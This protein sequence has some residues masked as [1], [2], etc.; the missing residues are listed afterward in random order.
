MHAYLVRIATKA[1][2]YARDLMAR[3]SWLLMFI[4]GRFTVF[5]SFYVRRWQRRTRKPPAH[6]A[7]GEALSTRRPSDIADILR[8]D[9]L[10]SGLILPRRVSRDIAEFAERAQCY[11]YMDRAMPFLA[12]HHAEA[13]QRYGQSI[14]VGHFLDGTMQCA[15][16]RE[17]ITNRWIRQIASDY[18]GGAARLISSRLWWSF[19]AKQEPRADQLSIASQGKFHY[20]L[21]DWGQVKV[22]FY[23]TDVDGRTGEHVYVRGS[24]RCHPLAVQFSPFVGV[25]RR[26]VERFYDR[27][28]IVGVRGRRGS[29]FVEDPFGLHMGTVLEAG[30]RLML[31]LSFGTSQLIPRRRYGE[32]RPG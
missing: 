16:A 28:A 4:F 2:V 19:P 26:L 13:E 27:A 3:P 12:G 29:G 1:P 8:R 14:L 21:D 10:A 9:G 11:A 18:L 5:R 23:L 25:S 22:F 31:E 6:P 24:H 32:L 30:R 15:A 17:V 20:D 7:S